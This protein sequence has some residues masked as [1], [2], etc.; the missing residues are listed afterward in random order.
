[1]RYAKLCLI[2]AIVAVT[3]IVVL[4]VT[5][6]VERTQVSSLLK[7]A[8]ALIA[9]LALGGAAVG[10]VAR[11]GPSADDKADRPIP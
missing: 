3:L 1:M 5:N 7:M 8:F 2:V 4:Y 9:I 6:V 10:T 11:S